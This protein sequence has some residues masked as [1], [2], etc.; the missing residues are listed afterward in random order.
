MHTDTTPHDRHRALI[1]LTERHATGEHRTRWTEN[2]LPLTPHE[3]VRR[4]GD[5]AAGSLPLAE[6]EPAVDADDLTDALTL[7]PHARAEFD[8][9][10]LGLLTM[11]KGRGMT[12]QNMAHHLG[13]GSAQ[14]AR[15]RHDR[16][17]RRLEG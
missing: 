6:G 12:W 3:A 15:Q 7:L 10:E 14:A 11:A 2:G 1:R 9:M 4:V 13:L 8:Q 17:T 5:L 16:L